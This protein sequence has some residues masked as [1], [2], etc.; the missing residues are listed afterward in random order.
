MNILRAAEAGR[1]RGVRRIG[2]N[3]MCREAKD[4]LEHDIYTKLINLIRT[5]EKQSDK[6]PPEEVLAETLGISRVK[7]RDIL[8]VLEAQGYINRRKGVGTLINRCLLKEPARIDIDAIYEELVKDAGHEPH[9]QLRKLQQLEHTP[10]QVARQLGIRPADQTY[11]VEKVIFADQTPAIFLQDYILPQYY[12]ETNID[13]LLLAKSTFSFVESYAKDSLESIVVH[14]HACQADALVANALAIAPGTPILRL[15]S[16]CYGF[17][18]EPILCSVEYHN[19]EVLPYCLYKR[20][21][22]TRF[23]ARGQ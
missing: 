6:L 18:S 20:L 10:E 23:Y 17:H 13:L 9:T 16:M 22:R 8:A 14:L 15:D 12:N 21:H 4:Q 1:R 2:V 3:A 7:L 19:T 5:C 11:L